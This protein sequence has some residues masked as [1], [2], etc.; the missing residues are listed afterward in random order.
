M[1][2]FDYAQEIPVR[3]IAVMLGL[4][5]EEG[6]RFRTWIH[7]ILEARHH[8]AGRSD[9]GDRRDHE[10]LPGRGREAPRLSRATI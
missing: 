10:I 7:E 8:P 3:V 4:P 9:E 6:D 5:E 2:R 1:P